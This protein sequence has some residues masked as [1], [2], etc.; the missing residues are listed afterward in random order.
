MDKRS[1]SSAQIH[2]WRAWWVADFPPL[3]GALRYLFYSGLLVLAWLHPKSP[4]RGMA[5]YEQTDPVFF[6]RYGLVEWLHVPYIPAAWLQVLVWVTVVAWVCAAI[7]LFQRV[8][9]VMTAVGVVILHGMFVGSNATNHAWY[10]PMYALVLMCFMRSQ[11]AW[12]VDFWVRRMRG[13][14]S[15]SVLG[16]LDTGLA[17]KALLVCAVGFYFSSGVAKLTDAGFRWLDGYPLQTALVNNPDVVAAGITGPVAN[18]LWVCAMLS[19][20]VVL[21]ELGA[22]F[23]L[24]SRRYRNWVVL[25]WLFLH[26]VLYLTI[27]RWY[28]SNFWC[29]ILVVDWS[30]FTLKRRQPREDE[31]TTLQL[32]AGGW[33]TTLASACGTVLLLLMAIT[34]VFQVESWPLTHVPMFSQYNSP[35]FLAGYPRKAYSNPEEATRIAQTCVEQGC[36]H[37]VKQALTSRVEVWLIRAGRRPHKIQRNFGVASQ[38]QWQRTVMA[39]MVVEWLAMSANENDAFDT[40]QRLPSRKMVR[41]GELVCEAF[42]CSPSAR[43]EVRYS[44]ADSRLIL[45]FLDV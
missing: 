36:S 21:I 33:N 24:V 14:T 4:L 37:H 38:K 1:G 16:V 40:S 23:A 31:T 9:V 15:S 27:E 41:Y 20:C 29:L 13:R 30:A 26:V 7:G 5:L 44:F 35:T 8:S 42:D 11:D 18:H 19:V 12:S 43:L 22:V 25:S 28:F 32:P 6:A 3:S 34:A 45:F 39:E 17:R 10:L 2:R